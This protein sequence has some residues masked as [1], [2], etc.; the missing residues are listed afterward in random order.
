MQFWSVFLLEQRLFLGWHSEAQ[1]TP[2]YKFHRLHHYASSSI[3][4]EKQSVVNVAAGCQFFASIMDGQ[5]MAKSQSRLLYCVF[6]FLNWPKQVDIWKEGQKHHFFKYR[7]NLIILA[8]FRGILIE[9]RFSQWSFSSTILSLSMIVLLH[10]AL[11]MILLLND[12][13]VLIFLLKPYI[14][15]SFWATQPLW[16]E[17]ITKITIAINVWGQ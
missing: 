4:A 2:D 12:S 10:D 8:N 1:N 13:L 17:I 5:R 7:G 9:S 15:L 6:A 11:T 14:V 16:Y 3:R